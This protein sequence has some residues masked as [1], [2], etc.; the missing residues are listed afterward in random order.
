[1]VLLETQG[2]SFFEDVSN[3]TKPDFIH[4]VRVLTQVAICFI[5]RCCGVNV[6]DSDYSKGGI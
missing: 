5:Q 3:A 1:M 6:I 4:Q 2:F